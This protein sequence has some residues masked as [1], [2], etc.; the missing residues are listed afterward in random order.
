MLDK[1]C[2]LWGNNTDLPAEIFKCLFCCLWDEL[3]G[4]EKKGHFRCR[5]LE[6]EE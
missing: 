6:R 4:P 5:S 1:C 3:C 2:V